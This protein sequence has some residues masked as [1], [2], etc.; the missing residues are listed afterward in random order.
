M[1]HNSSRFGKYLELF[2]DAA[3]GVTGAHLSH[4]LLEKSRVAV[5]H[6]H[7]LNFHI[8]YQL[9]AGLAAAKTLDAHSLTVPSAHQC[10]RPTTGWI[11]WKIAW[12]VGVA[13]RV[14]PFSYAGPLACFARMRCL[15]ACVVCVALLSL[16]LPS[17]TVFLPRVVG[18]R[19]CL[20]RG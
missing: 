14:W 1:N 7:E 4:Y 8:F 15:L 19:V 12:R 16:Y 5:R 10:G 11:E 9:Y 13:G 3:G 17:V 6:D 18:G 20:L 2:F